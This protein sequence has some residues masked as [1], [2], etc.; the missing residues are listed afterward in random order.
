MK[1]MEALAIAAKASWRL[2][3]CDAQVLAQAKPVLL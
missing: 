3:N 2:N 1:M